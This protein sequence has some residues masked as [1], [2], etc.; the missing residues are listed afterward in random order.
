MQTIYKYKLPIEATVI[1]H[2]PGG[3]N[4]C[5]LVAEQDGE[6][7][8]WFEVD[9]AML[10]IARTLHIVGTG[11]PVK[12]LHLKTHLGS[13]VVGAFVWHVYSSVA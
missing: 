10:E 5:V 1:L 8:I 11:Q 7:T 3:R 4:N 13:A 9:T 12:N 2:M 6:L